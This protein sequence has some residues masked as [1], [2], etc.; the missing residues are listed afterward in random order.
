MKT[1]NIYIHKIYSVEN[2]CPLRDSF[3][4]CNGFVCFSC[5]GGNFFEQ[6]NPCNPG[7]F[8]CL[9]PCPGARNDGRI[10][11]GW[12]KI[13]PNSKKLLRIKLAKVLKN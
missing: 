1:I 10:P 5:P 11:R 8:F 3:F 6:A 13:F 9:I 7:K 12:G 4:I 2:H